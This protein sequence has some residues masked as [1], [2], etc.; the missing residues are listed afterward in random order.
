MIR[1]QYNKKLRL[2]TVNFLFTV[3]V[4]VVVSI[5]NLFLYVIYRCCKLLSFY[6]IGDGLMH[7]YHWWNDTDG[8]ELKYLEKNLS[9]CHFVHYKRDT[10][11]TV[12][13]PGCLQSQGHMYYRI[14]N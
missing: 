12:I 2:V 14:C 8:V 5:S 11:R 3:D 13:G 10:E 9:Q 6:S 4:F 7:E 1:F